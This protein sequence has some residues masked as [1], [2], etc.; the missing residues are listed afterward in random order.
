[1]L[2]RLG[3]NRFAAI[4]DEHPL[5]SGGDHEPDR[6]RAPYRRHRSVP[7]GARG[8]PDGCELAVRAASAVV[9]VSGAPALLRSAYP[10]LLARWAA[11]TLVAASRPDLK[12]ALVGRL[13]R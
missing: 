2:I 12:R 10:Q 8:G 3:H 7:G 1:V 13:S 4:P 5:T 9:A 6:Q 11:F